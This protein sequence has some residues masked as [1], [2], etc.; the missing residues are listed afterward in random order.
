[1]KKTAYQRVA[2]RYLRAAF[3]P[4]WTA[5]DA[6]AIK[7]LDFLLKNYD[8]LFLLPR[9]EYVTLPESAFRKF[10]ADPTQR[11]PKEYVTLRGLIDVYPAN[12]WGEW[13]YHEWRYK[14]LGDFVHAKVV[15]PIEAK[16]LTIAKMTP[17]TVDEWADL[18]VELRGPW[19]RPANS[20]E[21][22]E[23]AQD[24]IGRA[25]KLPAWD[26]WI[27]RLRGRTVSVT[28]MDA[29]PV[30]TYDEDGD[31]RDTEYPT[32]QAHIPIPRSFRDFEEWDIGNGVAT[33]T[34]S[35]RD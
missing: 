28:P 2:S 14:T 11:P 1:M 4:R 20:A 34:M 9:D 25:M 27:N 26:T 23:L 22:K 32:V 15:E 12:M 16:E 17:S 10:F 3:N 33:F 19:K 30:V 29:E 5:G 13:D 6:Q 24:L 18:T 21:E 8:K 35:E 7:V 31:E